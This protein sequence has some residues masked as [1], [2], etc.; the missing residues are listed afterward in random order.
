MLSHIV[1]YL[2]FYT[3]FCN[4][5]VVGAKRVREKEN[6]REKNEASFATLVLHISVAHHPPPDTCS[7]S[8]QIQIRDSGATPKWEIDQQ[9]RDT[10]SPNVRDMMQ[11]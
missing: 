2:Y 9:Q 6:K 7:D 3:Y 8:N 4:K 10:S 1:L 5:N 11:P